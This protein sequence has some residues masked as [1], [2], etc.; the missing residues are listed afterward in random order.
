MRENIDIVIP[1]AAESQQLETTVALLRQHTENFDLRV[2][3]DPDLNVAEARQ[4][5]MDETKARYLCFLD[6]DS[7]MIAD[8]WLDVLHSVL[9]AS[10]STVAVF[11]NEI[12]GTDGTLMGNTTRAEVP[13]GPSCCMLIDREKVPEDVKWNADIGLRTG[14]IGGDFEEVEYCLQLKRR[15]LS[16]IGCG[17]V[18]FR[19]TGG[20]TTM[21]A[22]TATDR[23]KGIR[24]MM[25]LLS[26]QD[27]LAPEDRDFFKGL[28][29]VPADPNDDT[30]LGSGFSLRDCYKDVIAR[31]GLTANMDF[32]EMGL[33]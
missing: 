1:V 24:A 23:C 14:Y 26:I 16:L 20:K 11:G 32:I 19:H 3:I 22:F 27:R 8:G 31:N 21:A 12:W 33:V 17:D 30:M 28:N 5:A 9:I 29:Y 2:P 4:K 25:Q 18:Q 6:Y 13:W 15:G 7:E 10:P